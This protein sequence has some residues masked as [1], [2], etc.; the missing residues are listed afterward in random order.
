MLILSHQRLVWFAELKAKAK[1][2]VV[3][4]RMKLE[5]ELLQSCEQQFYKEKVV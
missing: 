5:K 4:K 2:E 1:I 3:A